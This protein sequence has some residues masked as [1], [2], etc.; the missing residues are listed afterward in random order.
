M[1]RLLWGKSEQSRSRLPSVLEVMLVAVI[2]LVSAG[3]SGVQEPGP[4]SEADDRPNI[5]F[6]L[7]D[8]LG[9]EALGAYGG[10]TYDTPRIDE[11][12]QN[13][14]T[15]HHAYSLPTC[16]PSRTAL[17][18]GQYPIHLGDL[19]WGQFPEGYDKART[20]GRIL[21]NAGYATAVAG[22]WQLELLQENPAHPHEM[23]FDEY[24][25]YG[26]HEGPRYW[27]PFLWENGEKR[28]ATGAYGPDLYVNFLLDFMRE[29]KERARPFFA[30]Y[31]MT[32]V[33]NVGDDW[34]LESWTPSVPP[35]HG[36]KGRY[37]SFEEM[38]AEADDKIGQL[39]WALEQMNLRE[40]TIVVLTSDNGTAQTQYLAYREDRFVTE[41]IELAGGKGE[42]TDAGVNVPLIVSWPGT[43]PPGETGALV[44]FSDFLPTFA[45]LADAEIDEGS[46][47][48]KSFAP[49]IRGTGEAPR[50]WAYSESRPHVDSEG[51]RFVRTRRWKLYNTGEFYDVENDPA[52]ETPLSKSALGPDAEEAYRMLQQALRGIEEGAK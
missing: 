22:K 51:R 24:L 36:P 42:L 33:H 2:G 44:D 15:F 7:L 14:L 35:P 38:L 45:A 17:M 43:T 1:N 13:G 11:L 48:G 3:W 29:Q 20:L 32:L 37:E 16:H 12:A 39:V 4:A 47:D 5:L 41:P 26:W 23:G 30:F 31:S 21:Q 19:E 8:D 34:N 27:S 46:Y 18:A 50:T 52:E 6:I 10:T 25:L 40:E 49:V 9:D 28:I